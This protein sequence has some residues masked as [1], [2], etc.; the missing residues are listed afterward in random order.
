VLHLD[1]AI[2]HKEVGYFGCLVVRDAANLSEDQ[3]HRLR[4]DRAS[5][6]DRHS[7]PLN[8][9]ILSLGVS[10][11]C[12]NV[13]DLLLRGMKVAPLSAVRCEDFHIL[14]V[15]PAAKIPRCLMRHDDILLLG[16][17]RLLILPNGRHLHGF[18]SED[19]AAGLLDGR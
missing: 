11:F 16:S 14:V 5:R 1:D 13:K 19:V 4:G 2:S 9:Q 12:Q 18:L 15:G 3:D 17:H 6:V 8:Y 7:D 10:N